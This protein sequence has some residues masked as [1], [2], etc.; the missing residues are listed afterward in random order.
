MRR[1]R[2]YSKFLL[3]RSIVI[4]CFLLISNTIYAQSNLETEIVGTWSVVEVGRISVPDP[5]KIEEMKEELRSITFEFGDDH[6]FRLESSRDELRIDDA[7]W[8]VKG[9]SLGITRNGRLVSFNV[10]QRDGKWFFS[11][12]G[13]GELEVRK[14]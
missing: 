8:I 14:D 5:S 12:A 9:N 7:T 13:V 3:L 4:A 10:Q 11:M 6:S 2:T 1:F